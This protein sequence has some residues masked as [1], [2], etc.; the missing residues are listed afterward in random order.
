MYAL[1][2][3]ALGRMNA[4]LNTALPLDLQEFSKPNTFWQWSIESAEIVVCC[5]PIYEEDSIPLEIHPY[6]HPPHFYRG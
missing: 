6:L 3:A 2:A 4:F 5:S 1:L